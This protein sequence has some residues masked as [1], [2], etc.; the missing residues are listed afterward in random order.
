MKTLTTIAEVRHWTQAQRK[1]GKAVHFV[2]TMGYFH[3]G[4]LNLMR[5]AKADGG[6]VIVSLFV[7]PTQFAPHEDL[8]K[9][10]RDFERDF[11]MAE[12]VG[13]DALFMPEPQEIYPPDFQ[14]KIEVTRLSQPLCGVS[15][16]HHFGGVAV[17]VLKLFHIVEPDRAYFGEKDYQQMR[18]IQQM[19]R[20][21]NLR[22]EIVPCPITREPDGLAMSSRNVYLSP[23]QRQ[24]ALSLNRALQWAQSQVE[25]GERDLAQIQAGARAI[26]EAEPLTRLDYVEVVH[27]DTLEPIAELH[28]RALL[29]LA[30][31]FGQ[32]RL[33]DNRVLS[34]D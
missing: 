17:V 23:E 22:V 7:N 16:P 27:A 8:A 28:D 31:Y 9:Y 25:S 33:I 3:E 18:L 11:A 30:V 12:S 10:P 1:A 26:I 21:L 15:R 20:D 14:T 24:A 32:T 4:H 34:V 13:V 5:Q 6:A 19:V 29:A 2:P